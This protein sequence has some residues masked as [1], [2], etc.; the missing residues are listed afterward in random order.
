[1]DFIFFELNIKYCRINM[2]TFGMGNYSGGELYR[3]DLKPDTH[4]VVNSE[5]RLGHQIS[6]LISISIDVTCP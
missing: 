2:T 5:H 4:T 6:M 1:M 3:G